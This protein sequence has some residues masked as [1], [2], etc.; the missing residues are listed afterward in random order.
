MKKLALFLFFISASCMLSA[1]AKASMDL[2]DAD[3]LSAAKAAVKLTNR[4]GTVTFVVDDGLPPEARNA[5]ESLRKVV[6]IVDVP[7]IA[8]SGADE[9]VR[10]FQF[11][12]QGDRIEFLEGS[13]Y[14]RVYQAGDCRVTSHLFLA[15]SD[16]GE[17]KQDGPTKVVICTR[18]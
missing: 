7:D 5:L 15:R 18:H 4:S 6:A 16:D 1:N 9:Y 11:R 8:A 14:P 17:W 2:T 3:W 13:V 12:P 10:I